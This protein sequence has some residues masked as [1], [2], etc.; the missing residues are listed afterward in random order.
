MSDRNG[1]LAKIV[2][3]RYDFVAATGRDPTHVAIPYS[4]KSCAVLCRDPGF[5]DTVLRLLGCIVTFTMAEETSFSW[6][7]DV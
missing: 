1:Y 7:E 5:G 3:A 6:K 4:H 2:A